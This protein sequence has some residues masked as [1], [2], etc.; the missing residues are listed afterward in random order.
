[1]KFNQLKSDQILVINV[2]EKKSAKAK[3]RERKYYSC[4]K[5]IHII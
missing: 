3:A 4:G 5:F 1:M 2:N